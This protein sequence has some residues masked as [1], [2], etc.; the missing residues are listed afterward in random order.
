MIV[1]LGIVTKSEGLL[2]LSFFFLQYN[3]LSIIQQ[4]TSRSSIIQQVTSRCIYSLLHVYYLENL[5]HSGSI[6]HADILYDSWSPAMTISSICI[7]ILSMLS[8]S[9]I[10]VIVIPSEHGHCLGLHVVYF[11]VY[12]SLPA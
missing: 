4:V 3:L 10:K 12:C 1:D 8:S 7:S 2:P 11:M 6:C 5:I 9:T